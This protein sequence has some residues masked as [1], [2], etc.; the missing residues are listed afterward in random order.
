MQW[1]CLILSPDGSS[2]HPQEIRLFGEVKLIHLSSVQ[3]N[4]VKISGI[5]IYVQPC[6]TILGPQGRI[7][8]IPP[9]ITHGVLEG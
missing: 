5:Q 4:S 8:P 9:L 2:A 7:R 6:A 1:F 3:Y